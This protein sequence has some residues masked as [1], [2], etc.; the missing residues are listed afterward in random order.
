MLDTRNRCKRIDHLHNF[1]CT[2]VPDGDG[3]AEF[4]VSD[5]H[6]SDAD[7]AATESAQTDAEPTVLVLS[8]LTPYSQHRDCGF[9]HLNCLLNYQLSLY[10]SVT[11][12]TLA[13]IERHPTGR[14]EIIMFI[15]VQY[16]DVYDTNVRKKDQIVYMCTCACKYPIRCDVFALRRDVTSFIQQTAL[17]NA[18]VVK[19]SKSRQTYS[20]SHIDVFCNIFCRHIK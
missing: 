3:Q 16:N 9:F 14:L 17:R 4:Q 1:N 15:L 19:C 18:I 7:A 2:T 12:P 5:R 10:K 20:R 13:A 8:T 6:A 11:S